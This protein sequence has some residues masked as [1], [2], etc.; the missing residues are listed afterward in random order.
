MNPLNGGWLVVA[1]VNNDG[2][3][4]EWS[5]WQEIY[6][7]CKG[8]L[9]FTKQVE[10]TPAKIKLSKLSDGYGFQIELKIKDSTEN[11]V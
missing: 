3:I 5:E 1:V 7:S 2:E 9:G 11:V 10:K 8:I 6:E 4:N